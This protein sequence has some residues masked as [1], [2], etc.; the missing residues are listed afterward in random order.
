MTQCRP[1]KR[2]GALVLPGGAG[3][4]PASDVGIELA[5]DAGKMPAHSGANIKSPSD[6]SGVIFDPSVRYRYLLWR[7]WQIYAPRIV[8]VMLNP[9]TADATRD[10]PTIRRCISFARR[11]SFGSLDVVNLFAY[12]ATEPAML[13]QVDDPV[14][15]DN[16]FHLKRAIMRADKIVLAWGNHGTLR[17][18]HAVFERSFPGETFFCLGLTQAGHPK[19]P[20]YVPLG[21]IPLPYEI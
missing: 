6:G 4:P 12:R 10:D 14:G 13:A 2:R 8:F 20:L 5:S 18:Q 11:W 7:E 19:H 17:E 3:V 16:E 9:S 1:L 15:P 21:T